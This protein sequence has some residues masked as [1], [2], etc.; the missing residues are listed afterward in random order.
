[1]YSWKVKTRA[2]REIRPHKMLEDRSMVL[3]IPCVGALRSPKV[4]KVVHSP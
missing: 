3:G 1:M 2:F 4:P